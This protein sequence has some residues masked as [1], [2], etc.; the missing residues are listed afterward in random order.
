MNH[1]LKLLTLAPAV[2]QVR[3]VD[4]AERAAVRGCEAVEVDVSS[5]VDALRETVARL[6]RELTVGAGGVLSSERAFEAVDAG[7]RFIATPVPDPAVFR[8]C[9]PL[10]I[11]VIG[12]ALTPTELRAMAALGA[13][14]IRLFPGC[15]VD[16]RYLAALLRITSLP[17][18]VC[19]ATEEEAAPLRE[20]GAAALFLPA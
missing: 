5:G 13:Q 6:G 9:A 3:T 11:P 1:T 7:A 17:L 16:A 4:E 2:L 18:A 10:D 8:T 12:E 20:A 19:C 14:M 15:A